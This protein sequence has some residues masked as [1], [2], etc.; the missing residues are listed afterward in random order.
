LN[1]KRHFWI[2]LYDK[3][4]F[5]VLGVAQIVLGCVGGANSKKG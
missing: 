2:I 4:F 1:E 3:F 5:E